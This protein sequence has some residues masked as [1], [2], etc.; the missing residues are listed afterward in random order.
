MDWVLIH[1]AVN[2]L[3]IVLIMVGAVAVVVAVFLRRKGV[4]RYAAVTVLLAG[5]T[6]PLAFITGNQ[7]EDLVED[8]PGTSHEVVEE[9]EEAA[10]L[11]TVVLLLAGLGAALALY[12]PNTAFKALFVVLS[13]GALGVTLYAAYE[14]GQIV[15]ESPAFTEG[16]SSPPGAG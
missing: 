13:L 6:A 11:A 4:W 2:H 5:L 10:T 14:G 15:H 7:A 9:H 1:L 12:R 16:A 3:P 8:R